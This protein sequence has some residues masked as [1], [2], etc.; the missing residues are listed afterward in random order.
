MHIP[1]GLRSGWRFKEK[2]YQ[3]RKFIPMEKLK[4][5]VDTKMMILNIMK[6]LG[7]MISSSF[8]SR[9]QEWP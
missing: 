4:S 3:F 5:T 6:T 7:F 8:E 1:N 2:V 9:V